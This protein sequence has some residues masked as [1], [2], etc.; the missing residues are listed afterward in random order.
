MF[1]L[2]P[3]RFMP[4]VVMVAAPPLDELVQ[5]SQLHGK[6]REEAELRRISEQSDQILHGDQ[7]KFF[8][9]VLT[10]RNR[11][12]SLRRQEGI[13]IGGPK[14]KGKR[15]LINGEVMIKDREGSET[16]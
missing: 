8:D 7:S 3:F 2:F 9:L 15:I 13:P 4:F 1:W 6:P 11:D 5:L 16:Y 10:N 12:I 14:R